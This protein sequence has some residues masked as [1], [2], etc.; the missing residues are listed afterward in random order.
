MKRVVALADKHPWVVIWGLVVFLILIMAGSFT[1]Y[2]NHES[3]QAE[4]DRIRRSAQAVQ[5]AADLATQ[6]VATCKAAVSAVTQQ[7]KLDDLKILDTIK[8][9]FAESGRPVPPI[10]LALEAEVSN[11]QPPLAAC[12]PKENP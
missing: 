2:I 10:Y 7:S 11:R 12:E 3:D 9:R 1:I 5:L 6:S 8:Q 4:Q